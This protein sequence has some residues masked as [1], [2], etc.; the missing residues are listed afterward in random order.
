MFFMLGRYNYQVWQLIFGE[1]YFELFFLTE[2]Q[3]IKLAVSFLWFCKNE[4]VV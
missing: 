1:D 3:V 4:K 2:K